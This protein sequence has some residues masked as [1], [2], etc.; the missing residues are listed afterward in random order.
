MGF[1][2]ATASSTAAISSEGRLPRF[3]IANVFD[4]SFE[5][6]CGLWSSAAR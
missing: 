6:A 2:Q 3:E 4:Q 1:V 5:R